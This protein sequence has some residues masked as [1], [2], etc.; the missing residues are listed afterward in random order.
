MLLGSE[1]SSVEV[2]IV[3]IVLV[4]FILALFPV[5]VERDEWGKQ[6]AEILRG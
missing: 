5:R 6:A 1:G 3:I 2:P 4:I